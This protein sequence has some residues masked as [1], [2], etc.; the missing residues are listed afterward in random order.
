MSS[1]PLPA[2]WPVPVSLQRARLG[3][4]AEIPPFVL[5][6]RTK[7]VGGATSLS[8]TSPEYRSNLRPVETRMSEE[9]RLERYEPRLSCREKTCY[10]PPDRREW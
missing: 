10:G 6:S 5:R 7:G 9:Q 1:Q 3:S 4:A 8:A 2:E